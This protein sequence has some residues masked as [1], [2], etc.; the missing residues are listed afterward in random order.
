VTGKVCGS[1]NDCVSLHCVGNVCVA[2][3]CADGIKNQGE[4][5]TDCSGPCPKCVTGQTCGAGTDCANQVCTGGFC[6]APTC[7]DAFKNGTETDL[8]CGGS[9]PGCTT[10]KVC[11]V[12]GDCV[13]QV[14][15]G[16][17]CAAATCA[18]TVKNGSETDTDCG[19]VIC[20]ACVAGKICGIGTDCQSGICAA[21][22]CTAATC[23]DGLKNG[24]ET[25]V[26]CGGSCATKCGPNKICSVNGDCAGNVCGGGVCTPNCFD[27][28][29]NGT[30]SDTDC[31]GQCLAK[32]ADGK[33]CSK[34][35]DCTNGSCSISGLCIP[36]TCNDGLLNGGE[37]TIDCGGSCTVCS[38]VTL[39]A[40]SATQLYGKAFSPGAGWAGTNVFTAKT[41]DRIGLAFNSSGQGIGVIRSSS[42]PINQ[43]MSTVYT[44]A[45]IPGTW[46]AFANLTGAPTTSGGP[47]VAAAPGGPAQAAFIGLNP[48]FKYYYAAFNGG[49]WSAP[50]IVGLGTPSTGVSRPGI[51]AFGS[52]AEVGFIKVVAAT[53]EF[54]SRDRIGGV[55]DPERKGS[56]A[57][58]ANVPPELITMS[59]GPDF[60]AV[61][62]DNSNN[63]YYTTR[64][65]GGVWAVPVQIAGAATTDPMSL[66]ALP[67]GKAVLA[68][69]NNVASNHAMAAFYDPGTG[70]GAVSDVSGVQLVAGAS[71]AV[72]HGIGGAVA[73]LVYARNSDGLAYHARFI[74]G[75]WSPVP[76]AV[77]VTTPITT[78]AI[79]SSP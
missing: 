64:S 24:T 40:G 35:G 3:T 71:V 53:N 37:T 49:L 21:G 70:W 10:G 18:D 63:I 46:S 77:D 65:L 75:S 26:D 29:K 72:T 78:V 22:V 2:P 74:S 60:M 9:C 42:A 33:V 69:R 7:A 36:A 44:P 1:N 14:C 25:D 39:L 56:V 48:D 61:F 34:G 23:S 20:A 38:R 41:T 12:A 43:V 13:S 19:G 76:A 67:G 73:E 52:N 66:D 54:D 59:S 51:T 50:E 32:C 17:T 30:E 6:A 55:W 11:A 16:F 47:S 8:N 62:V 4:S 45:P 27:L 57:A 79:A 5:D 58:T 31:G 28:V 68:F 15:S